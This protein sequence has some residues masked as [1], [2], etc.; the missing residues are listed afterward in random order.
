MQNRYKKN[1]NSY[2]RCNTLERKL[3]VV[4]SEISEMDE[5]VSMTVEARKD[6]KLQNLQK[7]LPR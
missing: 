7:L 3:S 2:G 1:E 5:L 6:Q 4:C